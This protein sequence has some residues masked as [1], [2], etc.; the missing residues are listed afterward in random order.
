MLRLVSISGLS[1]VIALLLGFQQTDGWVGKW[2]GEHREG[3][4]YTITV[5][6]K[7]RGMNRCQVHAEGIQT[8]YTLDC[9]AT[10]TPSELKVYYRSTKDG[11]FYADERVNRDQPLFVLKWVKG[12]VSWQWQQI[13]DG[14]MV[15]RKSR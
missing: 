12:S 1:L 3:V 15:M 9:Q 6:D 8:F 7:D 13:F 10:G 4:T 2:T 5:K 11:A 14:N